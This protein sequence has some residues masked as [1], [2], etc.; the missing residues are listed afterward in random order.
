MNLKFPQHRKELCMDGLMNIDVKY[1]V[2]KK[3]SANWC[4]SS[5]A[6]KL[7]GF[8]LVTEGSARYIIDGQEF[9]ASAGSMVNFKP[10]CSRLGT[11]E[12][13]SCVALD[14][15]LNSGSL[16]LP[17][18]HRFEPSDEL[19]RLLRDF[20][21]E[22]L[23]RREGY[24][25]KC[26]ALVQLILHQLF[27]GGGPI[28]NPYVEKIKRHIVENY[29]RPTD[30]RELSELLGLS[31]VYCG[32][33]FRKVQGVT[34]AEYANQIR[35]RRAAALLE[36]QDLSITEIAQLCGFSDVYYFSK[37]FKRVMGSSP[38]RYRGRYL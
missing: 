33:L 9:E 34:I 31:P 25:L 11:T 13:M 10:G 15:V 23:Q 38:S 12:G 26:S 18:H 30:V 7:H 5:E 3:C 32:A 22:W 6:F 29:S 17:V 19:D 21:F 28:Q 27:Y 4:V 35:A 14:F 8:L 24:K 1:F 36:E 2:Q 37:T 20:Q 16:N